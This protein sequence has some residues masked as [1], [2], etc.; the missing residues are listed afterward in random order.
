VTIDGVTVLRAHKPTAGLPVLRFLH[1]RLTSMW[2]AMK[3]ADADIYYQ[4][5]ASALTGFVVAFARTHGRKSLYAAASD[6]DFH[7]GLPQITYARDRS[8]FRWG[9]RHADAV[10]VQNAAQLSACRSIFSRDATLIANCYPLCGESAQHDGHVLWAGSVRANKNPLDLIGLAQAC[11]ALRFR[12]VGDGDPALMDSLRHAATQLRNIEVIG[13]VPFVDVEKHFDGAFALV[14]TSPAE[15]FPNTFLQAWSRGIPTVSYV[16]PG[17]RIEGR[18]VGK[19]GNT[20]DELARYLH[21]WK[22]SPSE[23]RAV[24]SD[25]RRYVEENSGVDRATADYENVFATI[26]PEWMHS[27]SNR[28]KDL[29]E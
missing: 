20:T 6:A 12:V 11:P 1:P 16:G 2:Q 8:L 29:A 9:L 19:T 21:T 26:F 4:R 28:K 22:A 15:G 17:V 10:V 5:S 25:G 24:G 18:P 23:W 3:R 13:F 27:T 7:A 14:N